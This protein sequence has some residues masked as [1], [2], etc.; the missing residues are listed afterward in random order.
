MGNCSLS[1]CNQTDHY[2]CN[3]SVASD[4]QSSGIS[5]PVGMEIPHY[6]R[7]L[8]LGLLQFF[9][10]RDTYEVNIIRIPAEQDPVQEAVPSVGMTP[11]WFTLT[12]CQSVDDPRVRSAPSSI[13]HSD[14]C[15]A[16]NNTN[17]GCKQICHTCL[18]IH[19]FPR[20]SDRSIVMRQSS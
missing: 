15:Q 6:E 3:Q 20:Q 4:V 10:Y 8:L 14:T 19:F 5:K 17:G 1:S 12:F 18:Q 7:V 9:T 11:S 13:K 2:S 16:Q